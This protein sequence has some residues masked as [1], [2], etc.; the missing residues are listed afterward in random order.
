[1]HQILADTALIRGGAQRFAAAAR[2]MR[3]NADRMNRTANSLIEGIQGWRG[4]GAASFQK[5]AEQIKHDAEVSG[6]AFQQTALAL[7]A[8]A[9]QLDVVNQYRV[10]AEQMEIRIRSLEHQVWSA[11]DLRRADLEHQIS[12]LRHRLY[13]L[14][15]DAQLMEYRANANATVAFDQIASMTNHLYLSEYG[16]GNGMGEGSLLDKASQFLGQLWKSAKETG[17]EAAERV[18]NFMKSD[19]FRNSVFGAYLGFEVGLFKWLKNT[20]ENLWEIT[21][22]YQI[23]KA[24]SDREGTKQK[25]DQIFHDFQH[26]VKAIKRNVSG[27]PEQAK[28]IYSTFQEAW[29]RD[30]ANGTGYSR[31]QW[32]GQAFG[33]L[34]ET[35]TPIGAVRYAKGAKLLQGIDLETVTVDELKRVTQ[36]AERQE[37]IINAVVD[38]IGTSI[39]VHPLRQS[40]ENEVAGLQGK[41]EELK[42]QGLQTEQIAKQLSQDRRDLGITYKHL[43]PPLMR[44]YIYEVNLGR[45]GDPLGPTMEWLEGRYNG[46][47]EKIIES[48]SRP[49]SVVDKLLGGFRVW[50]SEKVQEE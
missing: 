34:I 11:D 7:S 15:Q 37:E 39:K 17:E 28:I 38:E 10:Q 5:V 4:E 13:S 3:E 47:Y 48:S 42:A 8:L 1:M 16:S 43:T 27:I 22:S 45:Y 29:E 6:E 2:E 49:N 40:Y 35:V 41:A 23:Y 14:L 9:S 18:E 46:N 30:I 19:K 44:E 21:P 50:L 25:A 20:V 31:A 36:K 32:G 26:P 12:N 24:I 33:V